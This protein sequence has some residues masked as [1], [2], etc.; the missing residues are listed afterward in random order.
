MLSCKL[1]TVH[2]EH[3]NTAENKECQWPSRRVNYS[4]DNVEK[5]A[6]GTDEQ[7]IWNTVLWIT[8]EIDKN[9]NDIH[10]DISGLT[11]GASYQRELQSICGISALICIQLELE[12]RV[13]I[14]KDVPWQ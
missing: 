4:Q 3:G 1:L 14:D 5:N 8:A 2:D 6:S 12:V 11:D 13:R 10:E 7:R 9:I